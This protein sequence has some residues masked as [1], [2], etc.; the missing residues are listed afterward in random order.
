MNKLNWINPFYGVFRFVRFIVADFIQV[1]RRLLGVFTATIE[2]VSQVGTRRGGEKKEDEAPDFERILRLW[3]IREE[4]IG[5]V[6]AKLTVE[7]VC[8][9]LMS[10]MPVLNLLITAAL[11]QT[12]PA[13]KRVT[14]LIFLLSTPPLFGLGLAR[15]WRVWCLRSRRFVPFR[16]WITLRW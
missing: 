9:V 4:D 5:P 1:H 13:T 14:G 6:C 11:D 3:G 15:F 16:R 2:G 7:G 12:M 8:W 10:L